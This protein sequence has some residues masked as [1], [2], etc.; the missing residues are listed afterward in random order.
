M[1]FV[2]LNLQ[3]GII[4]ASTLR[5]LIDNQNT[6]RPGAIADNRNV[7]NYLKEIFILNEI[8]E[9]ICKYYKNSSITGHKIA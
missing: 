5:R 9:F 7:S 6:E 8:K 1:M 4:P 3:E 2:T